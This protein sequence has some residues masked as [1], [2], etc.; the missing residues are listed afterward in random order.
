MQLILK[1]ILKTILKYM[2]VHLMPTIQ[3]FGLKIMVKTM[4]KSIQRL[5]L[6]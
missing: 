1:H 5:G 2:E 3:K 6:V 4:T